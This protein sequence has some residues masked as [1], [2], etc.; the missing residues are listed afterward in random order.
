MR[1]RLGGL[2][3]VA[4]AAALTLGWKTDAPTLQ[5]SIQGGWIFTSEDNSHQ[6]GLIILAESN[7][8]I[9]YV[10]GG[11]ERATFSE[12]P[13]DEER[14]AAWSSFVA[15]SGRYTLE[16]NQI[17]YEAYM[18]KNPS[19]MADWPDNDRT[20]TVEVEGDRMTWTAPNGSSVTLRRVGN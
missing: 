11:E 13:S 15:N 20:A 6:R 14:L 12:D 16:G 1:T 8:S 3:F 18:A 10:S 5:E 9:M 19:Y 2:A 7:Y 17:T 4:V